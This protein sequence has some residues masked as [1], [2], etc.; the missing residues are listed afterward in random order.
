M[1]PLTHWF[2]FLLARLFSYE[3]INLQIYTLNIV[4]HRPYHCK[5]VITTRT[6]CPKPWQCR[7]QV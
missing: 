6:M 5:F 7:D 3:C 2:G 1:G 4:Q